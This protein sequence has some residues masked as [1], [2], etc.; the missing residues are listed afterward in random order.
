MSSSSWVSAPQFLALRP[1]LPGDF[2][3]FDNPFLRL[4]A[5]ASTVLS[6]PASTSGSLTPPQFP[7]SASDP[8]SQPG[9]TRVLQVQRPQAADALLVQVPLLRH[10]RPPAGPFRSSPHLSLPSRPPGARWAPSLAARLRPACWAPPSSR[11][12]PLQPGPAQRVGPRL[13]IG[14]APM[15]PAPPLVRPSRSSGGRYCQGHAPA[16]PPAAGVRTMVWSP[17]WWGHQT[18]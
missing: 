7:P 5:R 10:P 9:P 17:L 15:R 6:P 18:H 1:R 2:S 11:P 4:W 3:S 16:H 8:G 12:R 13:S 14:P